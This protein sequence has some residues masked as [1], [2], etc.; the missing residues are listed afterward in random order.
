MFVMRV[1]KT[2]I[3]EHVG[4][5]NRCA[6][7][8]YV[9]FIDYDGN[10]PH[11]WIKQEIRLL[12]KIFLLTTAYVFKT[13]NGH[14]VVFLEKMPIDDIVKCLRMT[15]CDKDHLEVPLYYARKEWVLRQ[16]NKKDETIT[17]QGPLH[18][19]NDAGVPYEYSNAHALVLSK[20]GGV[21]NNDFHREQK[22]FDE[23]TT[24]TL[25]Q[26]HVRKQNN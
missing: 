23:E 6:D 9:L 25:A 21:P 18:P 2:R 14:H 20:I 26:Y 24:I 10:T 3:Q 12:Q 22:L 19:K 7:G 4:I 15:T 11:E 8:N 17:Y 13:K 1:A 16:T 5:G